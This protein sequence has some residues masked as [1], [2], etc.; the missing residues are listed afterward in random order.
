M[1]PQTTMTETTTHNAGVNAAMPQTN[2]TP[3][4]AHHAPTADTLPPRRELRYFQTPASIGAVTP[5]QA[6]QRLRETRSDYLSQRERLEAATQELD[7]LRKTL[8]AFDEQEKNAGQAWRKGFL[9]SFGKQSK[10]VRDQK[11]QELQWRLEADQH[12]EMIAMLEP[13]VEWLR[14]KTL[15]ARFSFDQARE[16]LLEV[17]NHAELMDS[18]D[19]IACSDGAAAL[20]AALQPL[21]K[22]ITIDT[23]ND[24]A[25]M[26]QFGVD[27]SSKPGEGIL[28]YMSNLQGQDV[29]CEIERR[30][31]AAVGELLLSRCPRGIKASAPE[32]AEDIPALPCEASRGDYPS[33]LGVSRRLKELEAQMGYVP[34][35]ENTNGA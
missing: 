14:I 16:C 22:R 17:C 33:L 10:D 26:S 11:K 28:A 27:V 24:T 23:Y 13:Q 7:R 3:K 34:D 18:V 21:F 30:Q 20:Y 32:G 6:R 19:A 15:G 4:T 31:Y 8:K 9:S 25:F 5:E 2:T 29:R 12:R 35:Q 1:S